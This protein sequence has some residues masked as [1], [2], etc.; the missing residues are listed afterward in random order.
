M[1]CNVKKFLVIIGIVTFSLPLVVVSQVKQAFDVS[2][3]NVV[4]NTPS[5]NSSESMPCGGGDI[6]TNVWVEN[7]DVL[8]YISRSGTFDENG[9][10]PKIGRVRLQL[11][12]NPFTNGVFKQELH[13]DKGYVTIYGK[14]NLAEVEVKVWVDVFNPLIHLDVESKQNVQAIATYE[15]WRTNDYEWTNKQEFNASRAFINAPVKPIV[16]KDSILFDNN[17]VLFYHRNRNETIFDFTVK[18]QGLD[19]VKS[20]LWN[21]LNGLTFGGCMYADNMKPNGITTGVYA[22][23]GFKGWQLQSIQKSKH[24]NINIAVHRNQVSS[25]EV[26]INELKEIVKRA[27]SSDS[28]AKTTQDWWKDYWNRSHI[29]I[30]TTHPDTASKAWQIGRNYN[31]FRYQLGCNAY[32]NYP[33]NFN[34]GLFTFDPIYVDTS[35]IATPDHRDWGGV[36]FT[37]QNQRLLYWPMLK[38]GDFD[39]IAPQLNFYLHA[40]KNA[41]LRTK[42]Y[43][44]HNGASF[45]EQIELFGLPVAF[46]YGWN[47]P[48]GYPEGVEYNK[49]LEYVWDTALE[50]CLIAMDKQQFN[51]DDIAEYI[52]LIES[53]LT[54]FHEHYQQE[55]LKRTL[56][57]FDGNGKLVLFPGS[58]AETYKVAYN[59][60]STVAALQVV[61]SRLVQLP[62][63]YLNKQKR[64]FWKGVLKRI[65][66]IPTMQK[67]GHTVIAPA[68]AWDRRQNHEL[69]QLYPV[70]PWGVY[71]VGKP[72]IQLGIDT[73]KFG[74]EV[75][76][77]KDYISW[78]QD[79]ITCARLGLTEEAAE[80]ETK[81]MQNSQRR[82]PTFWGPGHDW[83]PDHNWGGSGMIGLQEMLMQTDS[84]KIYLFPSWPK[85][86]DVDFKLHAPFNTTVEGKL[87][88]GKLEELVVL[89]ESRKKDIKLMLQ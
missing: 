70:Y 32:G 48:E 78:H 64:D 25:D 23:T 33:T 15:S 87:H 71:G 44:G 12:P 16:R 51:G 82:F 59:A 63:S 4:W 17:Q 36:T 66:A 18:Q 80:I 72:N 41:E 60:S 38:S 62:D 55:S 21:P 40:L 45:S 74:A 34:G 27:N 37:A 14:N 3:Y 77:Q 24:F 19:S 13:L 84:I 47:R 50:F 69:S 42:V 26:F 73:W 2:Q 8:L 65:P 28:A 53:C 20:Q 88:N 89:P 85:E 10:M 11:T 83:V 54:F 6:G 79:A 43:W 5:K 22:I 7:G 52:P 68:Q 46:E 67:D 86:W 81:K 61:I 35:H 49:W 56:Q 29:A 31:V 76:A 9:I 1:K 30:N 57:P 58:G 39:M 75:P